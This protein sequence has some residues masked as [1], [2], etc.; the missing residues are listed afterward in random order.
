MIC[1]W[2]PGDFITN[3][4]SQHGERPSTKNESIKPVQV[5]SNQSCYIFLNVL[6]I[7]TPKTSTVR[8]GTVRYGTVRY[9]TVRYGTVRYGTVRYGT[10]RYGTVRYGTVRVRYGTVRYNGTV[11]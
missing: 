2:P 4:F 5:T 3:Y 10:V 11:K 1:E 9:G 7:D 6:T 8:Y